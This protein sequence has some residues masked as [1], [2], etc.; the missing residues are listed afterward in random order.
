[1]KIVVLGSG[2]QGTL[3][4]VRLAR[5]GHDVTL[6]ARG[7]RGAELSDRGAAI[8][9][10]LTNRTDVVQ[11]RVIERL[12]RDTVADLCLICVRRE[13]LDDA[14]PDL[15]VATRVARF[16]VM[17]NHANGS[18]SLYEAL[19]RQ[20]VVLGFPGAA[21]AIEDGV[22]RYVE[23]SEQATAI[24]ARAPDVAAIIRSAGFRVEL[25]PDMDSWLRRHAIFVTAI[26]GA[27]YEVDGD[28]I[29][30]ASD[31]ALVRTFII[32][33]CSAAAARD[34]PLGSACVRDRVLAPTLAIVSRGTLLCAP[35]AS[36]TAGDGRARGR[37]AFPH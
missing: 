14:L 2:V 28:P 15:V 18:D 9:N 37:R 11:L 31:S 19:S 21:G 17:V 13:Q 8:S 32:A 5:A 22:D 34:L 1:M 24:E 33:A 26:A 10:A 30:L 25:V 4:G 20:R 35:H 36:R 16:V 7:G 3:Y 12:T 27:L 6:I 29:R 23:V